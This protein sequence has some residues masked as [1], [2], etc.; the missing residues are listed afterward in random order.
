M[1]ICTL[2]LCIYKH[3]LISIAKVLS[4]SWRFVIQATLLW[5]LVCVPPNIFA[6]VL[7]VDLHKRSEDGGNFSDY[8]NVALS[9]NASA[10]DL[11]NEQELQEYME[12]S[13]A[14]EN[15]GKDLINE[16]IIQLTNVIDLL[17]MKCLNFLQKS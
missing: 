14:E 4:S 1:Y 9:Q 15:E 6:G 5:V 3:T 10:F 12:Y 11:Q 17:F 13:T 8:T 16:T 7:F 2:L